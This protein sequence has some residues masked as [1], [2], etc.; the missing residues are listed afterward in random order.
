MTAN[1]DILVVIPCLR[2]CGRSSLAVTRMLRSGLIEPA[3][4]E[5]KR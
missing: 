4:L 1:M 5:E 2:L 3:S